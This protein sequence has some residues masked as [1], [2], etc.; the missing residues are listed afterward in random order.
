MLTAVSVSNDEFYGGSLLPARHRLPAPVGQRSR[1]SGIIIAALAGGHLLSVDG[2]GVV[3][4][5]GKP[6]I[7]ECVHLNFMVAEV[8][9]SRDRL[10]RS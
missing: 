1:C 2:L 4:P 5:S 6:N 8:Y 7:E 9:H 3:S 10:T